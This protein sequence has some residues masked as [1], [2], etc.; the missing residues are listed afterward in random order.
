MLFMS[1]LYL[2][3]IIF[4]LRLKPVFG[5]L[6]WLFFPR[7]FLVMMVTGKII[8]WVRLLIYDGSFRHS[9]G[10]PNT[11]SYL[12]SALEHGHNFRTRQNKLHFIHEISPHELVLTIKLLNGFN[13][14]GNE[15]MKELRI[16]V[17]VVEKLLKL[18]H[19]SCLFGTELRTRHDAQYKVNILNQ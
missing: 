7:L 13:I 10:F 14:N 12:A 9:D 8:N 17:S 2:N 11:V 16:E 1:V 15:L 4:R 3:I 6:F 5:R 18:Q 19:L